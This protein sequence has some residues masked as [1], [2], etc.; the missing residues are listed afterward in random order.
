[1]KPGTQIAYLP[2]H[3]RGDLTHPDVEFGFVT[4][5]H[6]SQPAHFCRYWFKHLRGRLRTITNSELTPDANLIEHESYPPFVVRAELLA[7]EKGW[8]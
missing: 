8:E 4:S 7:L 1:M 6:P 3:A 5:Q 2:D